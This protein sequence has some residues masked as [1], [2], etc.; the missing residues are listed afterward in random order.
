MAYR[1]AMIVPNHATTAA[2]APILYS[3]GR[4]AQIH[5]PAATAAALRLKAK[6]IRFLTTA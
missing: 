6:G 4:R 5:I 3:L 1:L 2:D